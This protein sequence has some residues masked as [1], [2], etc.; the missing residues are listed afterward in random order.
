[1]YS[2]IFLAQVIGIYFIIMSIAILL[3][4]PRFIS[5]IKDLLAHPA[6]HLTISFN[7][8]VIGILLIISHNL[9]IVSW[10]VIITIVAWLIFLK[11]V[12]NLCFR[13]S[14]YLVIDLIH[15]WIKSTRQRA[16]FL[17]ATVLRPS[18]FALNEQSVCLPQ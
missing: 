14:R 9:W 4:V 5:I 13:W 11:G 7:I 2:S 17:A 3:N 18:T 16:K 10:P 8:L 15:P 6:M 12:V 1:M